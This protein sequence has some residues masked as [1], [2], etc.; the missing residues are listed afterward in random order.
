VSGQER[1]IMDDTR[2][3][4]NRKGRNP[5]LFFKLDGGK[6]A[7]LPSFSRILHEWTPPV[8]YPLFWP[9]F[10]HSA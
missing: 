9:G 6:C 2:G 7:R 4:V 5:N 10:F 8:Q 3:V 1:K